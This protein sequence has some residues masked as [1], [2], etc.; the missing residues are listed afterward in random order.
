MLERR[1]SRRNLISNIGRVGFGLAGA[2]IFG[3][4][5]E[6][7][8]FAEYIITAGKTK[9]LKNADD[10]STS[11]IYIEEVRMY[12]DGTFAYVT[13]KPYRN[14]YIDAQDSG[15][16]VPFDT[17]Y[18]I[19]KSLSILNSKPTYHEKDQPNA[20]TTSQI[21]KGIWDDKPPASARLAIHRVTPDTQLMFVVGQNTTRRKGIADPSWPG[22]DQGIKPAIMCAKLI[23]KQAS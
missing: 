21:L 5:V 8:P 19:T 13:M 23:F 16:F 10:L 20:E 7:Q 17:K 2:V 9:S 22:V 1:A 14:A 15:G 6:K 11:N 12:Y 3:C 4:E 18:D